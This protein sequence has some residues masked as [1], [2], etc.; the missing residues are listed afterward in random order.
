M[1]PK[2]PERKLCLF[3]SLIQEKHAVIDENNSNI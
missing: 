3:I 1:Q 2:E